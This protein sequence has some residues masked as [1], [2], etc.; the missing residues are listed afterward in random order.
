MADESSITLSETSDAST[1]ELH[2]APQLP[3]QSGGGGLPVRMTDLL[4]RDPVAERTRK[5]GGTSVDD[6]RKEIPMTSASRKERRKGYELP[7]HLRREMGQAN[8][9]CA[10]GDYEKAK[11]MCMELIRQ[12]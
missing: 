10:R 5:H 11:T 12:G 7:Q 3:S 6:F 8:I 9:F 2:S 1:Q 4:L